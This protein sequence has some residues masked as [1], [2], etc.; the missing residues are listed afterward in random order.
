MNNDQCLYLLGVSKDTLVLSLHARDFVTSSKRLDWYRVKYIYKFK[1][2]ND[3]IATITVIHHTRSLL[4][5]EYFLSIRSTS[6]EVKNYR[7]KI[8]SLSYLRLRLTLRLNCSLNLFGRWLTTNACVFSVYLRIRWCWVCVPGSSTQ[9]TN[10]MRRMSSSPKQFT[11]SHALTMFK[12]R[13]L[14]VCTVTGWPCR[15]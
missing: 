15:R 7:S 9:H 4:S 2:L 1:C 10:I 13:S 5:E 11:S 6:G 14:S 12:S 8:S 3:S